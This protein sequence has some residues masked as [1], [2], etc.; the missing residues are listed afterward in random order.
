[1][2]KKFFCPV[3]IVSASLLF[4]L[5]LVAPKIADGLAAAPR[6]SALRVLLVGGGPDPENNQAAIESNV[7]YVSRLVPDKSS[8]TTLFAD[9]DLRRPSV[10]FYASA[11][12]APSG[13]RIL[14][15]LL[16]EDEDSGGYRAPQLGTRLHG[17]SSK[18][19]IQK[20]FE[21]LRQPRARTPVLLYFTGHG[22]QNENDTA[23]N[24]YCLWGSD[25]LSVREL[26]QQIA[27]LPADVPVTLVM[28]QCYSGAF[29]NVLFQDG[30]PKAALVARDIAGFFAATPERMAAGCTAEVN[31]AEYHDFTSY[32]FAAL[33]GRDRV[34]R[35]VTGVDYNRDGRVGMDEAFY[36]TLAN[37][38]SIDVPVNTSDVF[39]RRFVTLP[40][41]QLLS[42]RYAT[43]RSW[44]T[45][46]QRATLDTLSQRAK[47]AGDD[48]VREAHTRLGKQAAARRGIEGLLGGDDSQSY[49]HLYE[50]QYERYEE[51]RNAARSR[52]V[53]R[54]PAL[55]NSR[56]NQYGAARNA[57]IAQLE[58]EQKAGQ[59]KDLWRIEQELHAAYN[60][61]EARELQSVY[62]LRFLRLCRSVALAQQL[63]EK[64]PQ[65]VR[66]R[67][68]RL[69]ASEAKSPLPPQP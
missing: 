18:A 26:S 66:T 1:M 7:R 55:K 63:R 39:L 23:N 19:A 30:N 52:L 48:R 47:L 17:P 22:G 34:G 6:T 65:N 33:T 54:W 62:T 69:L 64:G 13:E 38:R 36:Y 27:R 10:L 5:C 56:S 14:Q 25:N 28:V 42:T 58:R 67:F 35:R 21:T 12:S 43:L 51:M 44:A 32:F 49:D 53:Q 46:A 20:A 8:C 16:D 41:E 4:A 15:L 2:T 11:S 3:R 40:E 29:G 50:R 31:E 60:A 68:T 45:A 37:D 24:Y 9:G 61:A 57:A 59:F